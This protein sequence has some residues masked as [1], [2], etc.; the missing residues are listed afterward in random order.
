MKKNFI[1]IVILLAMTVAFVSCEQEQDEF[2]TTSTGATQTMV[3]RTVNNSSPEGFVIPYYIALRNDIE[4][5][6]DYPT[7]LVVYKSDDGGLV[8]YV[9]KQN[10]NGAK[11]KPDFSSKDKAEFYK[12]VDQKTDEGYIVTILKDKDGTYHGYLSP[13]PAVVIPE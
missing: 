5:L 7:G 10:L 2:A 4:H 1:T 12:W 9:N 11:N 13:K 8:H 6:D 3:D